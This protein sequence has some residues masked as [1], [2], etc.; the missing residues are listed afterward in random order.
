M[1]LLSSFRSDPRTLSP[2]IDLIRLRSALRQ[3]S[4]TYTSYF[5]PLSPETIKENFST[6]YL[7]LEEM[8]SF[9]LPLTT[10]PNALESIVPKPS[11][12]GTVKNAITGEGQVTA[13]RTSGT[14]TNIPWRRSNVRYAQNE[15]YVDLVEVSGFSERIAK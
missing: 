9:G 8:V 10:H 4:K 5:G 7:L 12:L 13:D 1:C 6:C 2:L 14:L 3:L 11:I 15:V